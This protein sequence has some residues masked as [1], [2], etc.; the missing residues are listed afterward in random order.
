MLEDGSPHRQL[1]YTLLHLTALEI[2]RSR[3]PQFTEP[4]HPHISLRHFLHCIAYLF[5][6][7]ISY[8][9]EPNSIIKTLF[10]SSDNY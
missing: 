1:C 8:M 5:L 7:L 10:M 2:Q 9:T 3:P 4:T 6:F